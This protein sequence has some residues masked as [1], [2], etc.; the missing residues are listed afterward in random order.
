M[1]LH[2]DEM[3][4]RSCRG[5]PLEQLPGAEEVQAGAETGLADDQALARLERGEA[6]GQVVLRQEHVAG[7]LDARDARE[8]H[9][10]V[11]A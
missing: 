10:A 4:A 1:F 3:Q 11:L 9:V 5:V 2:A 8:I 6:R 7:F